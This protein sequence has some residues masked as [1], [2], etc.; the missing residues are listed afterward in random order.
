MGRLSEIRNDVEAMT[1]GIW[2]P[3]EVGIQC[4]IARLYNDEHTQ[5]LA[6]LNEQYSDL[7]ES[8]KTKK[9]KTEIERHIFRESVARTILTDWKNL[10]DDDGSPI[11]HN[12]EKAL[13]LFED[14]RYRDFY[15]FVIE[16]AMQRH[17]YR[18]KAKRAKAKN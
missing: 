12:A 6:E 18:E 16:T 10:D 1:K 4:K 2:V 3:F 11:S 17:L 7:L 13:E 14:P 15:D 5:C 8:A 9:E